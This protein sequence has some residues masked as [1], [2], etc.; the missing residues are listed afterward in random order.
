MQ[1]PVPQFS[2]THTGIYAI[3]VNSE[4]LNKRHLL[5][6]TELNDN[7]DIYCWK[8]KN[9]SKWR[10]QDRIFDTK[11]LFASL[12]L[13]CLRSS[14]PKL[15]TQYHSATKMDIFFSFII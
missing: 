2:Q 3:A 1:V 8:W 5:I 15:N 4:E 14:L 12:K 6:N 10:P 13:V 9:Y 7:R 11:A